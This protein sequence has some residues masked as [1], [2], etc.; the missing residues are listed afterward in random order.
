MLTFDLAAHGRSW[1][2]SA[3]SVDLETSGVDER[4]LLPGALDVLD[5]GLD[6]ELALGAN[7]AGDKDDFG[8]KDGERVDHAVDRVDEVKNLALD[9]NIEHLLG[10]VAP[11]DGR[12]RMSDRPDLNRQVGGHHV[13]IV[14]QVLPDAADAVDLGLATELAIGP[15]LF[16]DAR[17]LGREVVERVNHVV[18]RVLQR[19][20]EKR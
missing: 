5:L 4:D 17:D 20:S 2:G 13:D 6:A 12:R 9:G 3:T 10:Q 18:D 1:K 11:G 7:L 16:C 19:S 15:D 8:G 14:R